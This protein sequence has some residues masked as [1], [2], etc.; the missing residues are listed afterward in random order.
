MMNVC[1]RALAVSALLLP[2]PAAAQSPTAEYTAH[3]GEQ[4]LYSSVGVRLSQ[5]RQV[6]RQD[7][8]NYHR[9]GLQQPGDGWD[10]IFHDFDARGRMEAALQRGYISPEAAQDI[11]RGGATVIVRVYDGGNRVEVDVLR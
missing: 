4:D 5:P 2:T 8:A 10:P 7:R 9:F 6:L 1:L 11:M 3:I